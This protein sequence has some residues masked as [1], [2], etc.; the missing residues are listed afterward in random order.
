MNT[1][2]T[3]PAIDFE[4]LLSADKLNMEQLNTICAATAIFDKGYLYRLGSFKAPDQVVWVQAL[5]LLLEEIKTD[6]RRFKFNPQ[7]VDLGKYMECSDDYGLVQIVEYVLHSMY[8]KIYYD[9]GLE[10]Q[11]AI[12]LYMDTNYR[13]QHQAKV[14]EFTSLVAKEVKAKMVI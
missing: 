14:R 5:N 8:V 10:N 12:Y 6:S 9:W 7:Y 1:T 13:F 11:F 2:T 4:F 3:A